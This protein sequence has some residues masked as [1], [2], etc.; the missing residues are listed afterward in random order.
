MTR[1]AHLHALGRLLTA[2]T[3]SAGSVVAWAQGPNPPA[4]GPLQ[5]P[6][7]LFYYQTNLLVDKNAAELEDL[8]GR[9]AK[10]GYTG[11]VLTDSKFGRLEDMGPEYFKNIARVKKAAAA[12]GLEIIPGVFP[13]GWSD[14]LLG[15]DPNLIEGLPVHD[16]LF[17]VQAGAARVQADPPVQL[18]GGDFQ[19]LA[20]WDWKDSCVVAD[21]GSAKVID[22][23]GKNA[24]LVQK[25]QV[26]PYRQYR[27]SV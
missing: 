9:A 25:L 1:T 20:R 6:Q 19:D 24:R 3:L 22:S 10:A 7:R 14:S 23:Q 2:L 5:L 16:A 4:T 18:R 11:V 21:H 17:V 8:L 12:A 13:L 26:S 15:H 27:I